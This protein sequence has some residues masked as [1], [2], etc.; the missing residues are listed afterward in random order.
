MFN[1]CYM[2]NKPGE[3]ISIMAQALEKFYLQKIRA[4]P[5]V[6]C[7][8]G[9]TSGS[10][11]SSSSS[12]KAAAR[13]KKVVPPGGVIT[14]SLTPKSEV[15]S[16]PDVKS[17]VTLN[18]SPPVVGAST[19]KK[20]AK[21]SPLTNSSAPAASASSRPSRL[22][23]A[24]NFC[25]DVLRDL[26]SKRHAA[27]AW[28][29]YKPVDAKALGLHDYFDI[30]NQPMDLGT[31]KSKMDGRKY[32]TAAEFA[33]DVRLIFQNCFDYNP[34]T[35][36]VVAMAK[37]LKQ[38]FEDRFRDCPSEKASTADVDSDEFEP[39]GLTVVSPPSKAKL[40]KAKT[41]AGQKSQGA[42]KTPSIPKSLATP[43][44]QGA[45]KTPKSEPVAGL[46][47]HLPK[48]QRGM[49]TPARGRGGGHAAGG[50][51]RTMNSVKKEEAAGSDSDSDVNVEALQ[52]DWNHRLQEV[53][54][55]MRHLQEQIRVLVEESAVRKRRKVERMAAAA[56]ANAAPQTPGVT[57]GA[58]AA[59]LG[60][61][62]APF[63][64]FSDSQFDFPNTPDTPSLRGK[65]GAGRGGPKGIRG[66][67][68]SVGE[69]GGLKRPRKNA[70]GA[71][72]GRGGATAGSAA[73]KQR[74]GG[75][76]GPG[77]VNP[78]APMSSMGPSG[79][80][81]AHAPGANNSFYT[82]DDEDDSAQPMSYD[83]KRK[84]SLDI[85]NLPGDKIGRV[86]HII[87]S[88]EP[89]LRES[90][91]DEIEIDFETL[92]P[93][94]LRELEKYVSNCLKA[95]TVK[96]SLSVDGPN[97]NLGP[98]LP[99]HAMGMGGTQGTPGGAGPAAAGAGKKGGM[100]QDQPVLPAKQEQLQSK[101]EELEKRLEDVTKTLG[102]KERKGG[103][104]AKAAAL[105][106]AKAAAAGNKNND[107][108]SSSSD[109]S[110]S[111]DSSSSDSDSDSESET[112]PQKQHPSAAVGHAA[113]SDGA[114]SSANSVPQIGVRRD[115]MPN[116]VAAGI[117][118][119][120]NALVGAM[121]NA[122]AA[123]AGAAGAPLNPLL[124]PPAT[125][126][127]ASTK[128]KAALKGWS[129]LGGGS[130]DPHSSASAAAMLA[131]SSSMSGGATGAAANSASKSNVLQQKTSDTFAAF[132]K[133]AKEKQD[134]A[135]QLKEQQEMVRSKK[136]AAERERQRLESEKRKEREEEEMLEM[137]RKSMELSQKT[138]MEL[139]GQKK[140]SPGPVIQPP[141]PSPK[142][143][144][145][146]SMGGGGGGGGGGSEAASAAEQARMERERQR[147]REQERRRREAK[148]NQIDMNM[149]SDLMAA[150]E[151]NII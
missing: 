18:A 146:L 28:P 122:A 118:N 50:L 114:A 136:E 94:T 87:Q 135:Q 54:E 7:A 142:P 40:S 19:P 48:P 81:A 69:S 137:A 71:G 139:S 82:S 132:R 39:P 55:Q 21:T 16:D 96:P 105:A 89:S 77:S 63:N 22:S 78:M 93:S 126:E 44:S 73:K 62:G 95:R 61:G 119:P 43:K 32:S 9:N 58:A 88:R 35:H 99:G 60:G 47:N 17:A 143:P 2:Y 65:G 111:S 29:F 116:S 108:S 85:N 103:R 97:A 75:A 127:N 12:N 149:Q 45:L 128:T 148:A 41:P 51:T 72:G 76:G 84:L 115:L 4:M 20:E 83:E 14:P 52:D 123:A 67:R 144:E 147:Q 6:E 113:G 100:A 15:K 66:S 30:I 5:A 130:G 56:A 106:S 91:P 25:N 59:G 133:A 107:A 1:N 26:F 31:V 138:S 42:P 70:A 49:L 101:K 134:R 34:V 8:V 150:F 121:A 68:P 80:N 90:N 104:G 46:P 24:L 53:Q 57:G 141:Q 11:S 37:K 125:M 27:C 145:D 3:D 112:T 131:A 13:G 33:S 23:P 124:Q 120:P 74:M 109:S 117:H 38:V 129:S 10:N 64:D 92:K 140:T 102:V 98:T 79:S 110:D 86:V 151:E 36:D